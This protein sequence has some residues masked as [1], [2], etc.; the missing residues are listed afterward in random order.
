MTTR[1]V[2]RYGAWA[3]PLS[4]TA[5]ATA[6]AAIGHARAHRGRLYWSESRPAEGG[7]VALLTIDAD[8]QA[9]EVTPA[10]FN[11]RTRVHEYGGIAFVHAGDRL[12][13]CCDDDQR[14]YSLGVGEP[15][16]PLTPP[17]LRYADG[18]ATGDGARVFLVRED[19]RAP[20][21]PS[22]TIVAIDPARP[23]EGQV[24]YGESDFVA[25]PR[26][27]AD[28]R[29]LAFVSWNHPQMPWDGT[30]LL[31]GELIDDGLH[32]VRSIAG[33]DAESV[34][35]PCWDADGTLYFLSDRDGWWNL[36]RWRGGATEQV[37]RLDAEIGAPLWQ[38]GLANYVLLGD[39]RALARVCRDAI[40]SLALIDLDSGA[41]TPLDLPY[42]GYRSLGRL[43]AGTAFAV[44]SAQDDLPALI[45]IDL[46]TGRHAI[47]RRPAAAPPLPAAFVSR[48]EPIEFPTDSGPGGERRTAH[49]FFF[50]PRN[51][52]FA[53]PAGELPPLIVTLHGGPTAHH[54][55]DLH[56]AK[57]FFTT[58]GFAVVDV[59]YG[60]ST[61]YG[62]A[63]RERLRGG[64]GVVDLADT[65]A[66]VRFLVAAGRVDPRR[67]VIRGGSAGG[68][69][70][71]CALGFTDVFAAGINYFGVADLEMLA[72][73]THKFESRYTDGL[74]APLPQG[75]E[76]YR[77][78]SPIHH[79]GRMNA[80]LITLQGAE[81]RVVPPAQ[82]RA[83]VEAV[84]ARGQPVAYLEFEGEQHGFRRSVDGRGHDD[85]AL[86]R[87]DLQVSGL[88]AGLHAEDGGA[89]DDGAGQDRGGEGGDAGLGRGGEGGV[90]GSVLSLTVRCCDAWTVG[91]SDAR[92]EGLATDC[93][94]RGSN[95]KGRFVAPA[96]GFAF[97]C[98]FA[99]F[100]RAQARFTPRSPA[101]R[102]SGDLQ[103]HVAGGAAAFDEFVRF[104]DRI[105]RQAGGDDVLQAALA[106]PGRQLL[107]GRGA[108]GG[109]EVVD[110]EEAQAD[111]LQDRRVERHRDLRLA[112]SVDDDVAVG[113]QR[114]ERSG[115]VGGEVDL[116][117]PLDTL[118][119]G[120]AEHVR[121]HVL[122]PV[123]DYLVGAGLQ[124]QHRLFVA[125]GGGED[126]PRAGE[127]GHLH[128][129]V[130]DRAR[131]AGH[132]HRLAGHA[133]V[134]PHRVQRGQR[135]NAEA[136][137]GVE[138]H[139]GRQRHRLQ[140]RQHDVLR[141]GAAGPLPGR[142]PHPD[143]LADAGGR[144]AIAEA[145][146]H[147]GPVAVRHDTRERQFLRAQAGARLDVGGID[148]GGRQPHAHLARAGL[149]RGQFRQLQ[150]L[151]CRARPFVESSAHARHSL[152]SPPTMTRSRQWSHFTAEP[153]IG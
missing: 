55:T 54:S 109:A 101:R 61:G 129:V 112:A 52:G 26:P 127:L 7:R 11:L 103:H 82:S 2:A 76:I 47:V 44:A 126:L 113:P 22:N 28:A 17:G 29:R 8:R 30:R 58:R 108:V 138:R 18:V 14:L 80:A 60:G 42:V 53:A 4:A 98:G 12:L 57:Q 10:G 84:R 31:V 23:S 132:Q 21:E 114:G 45:T 131:A 79:L 97:H 102:R 148:S 13:A 139:A 70:V 94:I 34:S 143:P 117:H 65:V 64:W 33:G 134:H 137:A 59:N 56:L 27:D 142:V 38:L 16:Q 62:R 122:V 128:R 66:A 69:T 77:A 150:H 144:H 89:Q 145:V 75:R 71:L 119:A 100:R 151:A 141:G 96:A 41:A 49:A 130:A 9:A 1:V 106:Q 68:Y 95:C 48:G 81:D 121:R 73:D 86:Q 51:P 110:D 40:D 153:H 46:S 107:D 67:V 78:R 15:P 123:V 93:A 140:R 149:G 115:H 24:L 74:I 36:H 39:G 5:L 90:H 87:S 146:D 105:E 120:Q 72:A 35:E 25:F 85:D 125:A 32:G 43:D 133:A 50:A 19:H 37:T 135:R 111:A 3:S 20:G 91:S 83:I 63:Y 118:A 152:A 136:G 116:D 6:S 104:G 92:R 147:A 88:A 99:R 124:R